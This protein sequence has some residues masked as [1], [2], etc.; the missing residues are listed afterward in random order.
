MTR[1]GFTGTRSGMSPAQMVRM[2]EIIEGLNGPGI[3]YGLGGPIAEVHHGDCVGADAEFDEICRE[4]GVRRVAHPGLWQ[5]EPSD[6]RAHCAADEIREPREYRDR[7]R[8]IV[9]AADVL[10]AAP[11]GLER[12]R[13]GTWSTVRY[14]RNEGVP[15]VIVNRNG[16]AFRDRG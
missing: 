6:Y 3:L 11:D 12:A 7:N 1:L 4:R 13:S 8:D 5:G 9:D 10:F 14:A 15:I 16:I 2:A